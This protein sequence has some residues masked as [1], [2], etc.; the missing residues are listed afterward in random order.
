MNSYA[1]IVG[2]LT[3]KS[4]VSSAKTMAHI[5]FRDIDAFKTFT[6]ASFLVRTGVV[7]FTSS[8][9]TIIGAILINQ[10]INNNYLTMVG[11][12]LIM[13]TNTI[14]GMVILQAFIES[15]STLFV[16]YRFDT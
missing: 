13:F 7:I 1:I 12:L 9:P 3:G 16:I 8:I 14:I 5:A 11:S 10:M 2:A 4:F 15:V 6:T